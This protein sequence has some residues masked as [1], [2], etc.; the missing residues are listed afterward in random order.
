MCF[1]D[2]T[3]ELEPLTIFIGPNSSGKSA[4]FKALN[5]CTRL[6]RYPIRGARSGDF[7]VEPGITLDEAVRGG[8]TS[9][10]ITFEVWFHDNDKDEPDYTLELRRSYAGWSVTKEKF[11]FQGKWLDTSLQE[12]TF[13]LAEGSKTLS[14]PHRSTLAYLTANY[15]QDSKAGPYLEPIQNLRLRLGQARRYRPSASDIASFVKP[16]TR[17]QV[18]RDIVRHR[19]VDDTGSGLAIALQDVW[20]GDRPTFE[21][22]QS[23]L[24]GLHNHIDSI[25][26]VADWRGTGLVYKTN[27]VRWNTPACLESDGVLL[28]TLLLWRIHTTPPNFKLC[29]EE[30]ENGV[31]ISSLKQRYD[32]LKQFADESERHRGIQLLIATHSRDLLNAIGSRNDILKEIRVTEFSQENGTEIHKLNHYREI[33]QLLKECRYQMG[34]L[35][36]SNRL[37]QELRQSG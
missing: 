28:S 34:D 4:L 26:F 11:W 35:W 30:P 12:F 17:P 6:L 32:L 20:K 10:P 3:V 21:L 25:D 2:T 15:S 14:F 23:E 8:D 16:S 9:L 13:P 7:N 24:K 27:R 19:E 37:N 29:L 33:D 1:K 5:T 36:W 22:I 31:H 18:G